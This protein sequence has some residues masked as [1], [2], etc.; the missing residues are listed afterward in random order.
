MIFRIILIGN[1]VQ[2]SS[3]GYNKRNIEIIGYVSCRCTFH[4][5]YN[6]I[7]KFFKNILDIL[8]FTINRS[9]FQQLLTL[10]VILSCLS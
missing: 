5:Y 8:I 7:F 2:Y 9:V 3:N 1:Y 10:N 4:I 6:C